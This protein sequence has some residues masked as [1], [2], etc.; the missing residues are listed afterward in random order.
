MS[1]PNFVI[2]P[3]ID[4]RDGKVV[5]LIHGDP[6]RQ[7]V[8]SNDPAGFASR[9]IDS[10]AD[11]LH[12][13]NLSAAFGEEDTNNLRALEKITR[14][15]VYV[16]YGGG[17]RELDQVARLINIGVQR[18]Y[19][20]TIA[21]QQPKLLST[22]I[23]DFGPDLIAAD[24]AAKDGLVMI[25]GWQESAGKTI[26]EVGKELSD[27]GVKHC[28][29]TDI[30]RDG[31]GQGVNIKSATNFQRDS[32]LQV[33]ASGGVNKYDEILEAREAGLAG[34]II[35]RALYDGVLDLR[36]CFQL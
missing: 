25:K 12:I 31:S 2:Y 7:T 32:G 16:E 4:L 36:K 11:W 33:V 27:S 22:A 26:N 17:V 9:W 8:Y 10:G 24:L 30:S 1:S 19:F 18:V 34:I 20:G 5:R 29:L 6:G 35:G 28:V 15:E 13:V 23:Q 21:I 3:A 14:L